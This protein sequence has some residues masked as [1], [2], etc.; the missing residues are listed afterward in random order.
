MSQ[1]CIQCDRV[2][3]GKTFNPAAWPSRPF[4]KGCNFKNIDAPLAAGATMQW[5]S[6]RSVQAG[7]W[8]L[9]LK[10]CSRQHTRRHGPSREYEK[11]AWADR[12]GVTL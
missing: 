1:K 12:T 3:F 11:S 8:A 4:C 5:P 7:R 6:R 2:T 9:T 10:R